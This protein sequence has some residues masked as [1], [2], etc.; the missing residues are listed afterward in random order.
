MSDLL[1]DFRL[2]V[3]IAWSV[4]AVL[5]GSS[6]A[7]AQEALRVLTTLPEF[8]EMALDLSG[9]E[10]GFPVEVEHLLRGH[11][12]P[13]FVEALP[14][15]VK[16]ASR[17][18][19]VVS[20][21]LELESAW[22]T[23]V[24]AKSGRAQ[25]QKGGQGYCELG[26]GVEVL[27][28]P[29]GPISRAMGDVHASGNPHFYLSPLHLISAAKRL[30]ECL[31]R[32][33]PKSAE[34]VAANVSRF[35]KRMLALHQELT[36]KLKASLGRGQSLESLR[37][38]EYHQDFTYFFAAYG[39]RSIGAIE[40]KPGVPPSAARIAQAAT[41]ARAEGVRL[42]LAAT[43]HPD[44]SMSKFSEISGIPNRRWPVMLRPGDEKFDRIEKLHRYY[45][46]Q[47]IAAIQA[48]KPGSTNSGKSP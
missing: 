38:I 21:G 17:A 7:Q 33:R 43:H 37:F 5:V 1:S 9:G 2:K 32:L 18:D 4:L 14:S 30:G 22:L 8:A 46:E 13:H 20:V 40:E 48:S 25:V 12:D 31:T 10:A 27:Q 26:A 39:L 47:L 6:R 15:F 35:E 44:A 3:L 42:A 41:W 16:R 23:K 36:R 34:A 11:E 24:L 29:Q 45:I 19:L 28:K